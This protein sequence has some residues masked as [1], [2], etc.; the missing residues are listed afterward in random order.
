MENQ[1]TA[2]TQSNIEKITAMLVSQ[3]FMNG[4]AENAIGDAKFKLRSTEC[5]P[6]NGILKSGNTAGNSPPI[7]QKNISFKGV[8]E[9]FVFN[10]MIPLRVDNI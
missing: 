6:I 4:N 1:K 7:E 5:V 10:K 9:Y 3:N 2:K 8:C